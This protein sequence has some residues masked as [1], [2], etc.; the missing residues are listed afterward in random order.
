M[1]KILIQLT[2]RMVPA[3]ATILD[4]FDT[5]LSKIIG[6]SSPVTKRIENNFKRILTTELFT[7]EGETLFRPTFQKLKLDLNQVCE[8]W[9]LVESIDW[10]E[11]V[12]DYN[13]PHGKLQRGLLLVNT[14]KALANNPT[15]EQIHCSRVL[16]WC[17][18]LLQSCSLVADDMMDSSPLRRGRPSW[19]K[20]D[21]VGM[22]AIND[23]F[24]LESSV[25]YLLKKYF[26]GTPVYTDLVDAFHETTLKTIFGQNLDVMASKKKLE[27]RFKMESFSRIAKY[28]TSYYTFVMPLRLG[29]IL[30]GLKDSKLYGKIE[31]IG[32][33][34]GNIFQAQDDFLDVY[35]DPAKT[36]KKGTDISEGKCTWLICKAMELAD[37]DQRAILEQNY[38]K[39]DDESV[40]IVKSI[41][42]ELQIDERFRQYRSESMDKI[43]AQISS[44]NGR[45]IRLQAILKLLVER[46]AI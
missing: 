46:L 44:I 36:G 28:K 29:A 17:G 20:V 16:G 24:Y 19:Y 5:L 31:T 15:E 6:T 8:K 37:H 9:D 43:R 11:N 32:L 26:G 40:L 38:G 1:Y 22:N 42:Q 21:S 10:F 41:F 7:P 23:A 18:E 2:Y 39:Q 33:L 35:G 3:L 34:L 12:L 14:F 4:I 27:D 30:A 13:V 45:N 25:Y